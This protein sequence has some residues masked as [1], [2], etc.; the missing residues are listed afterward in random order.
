[1]RRPKVTK[2]TRCGRCGGRIREAFIYSRHTGTFYCSDL[3]ACA[4]RAIRKGVKA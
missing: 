4:K 1:M 3:T 2:A